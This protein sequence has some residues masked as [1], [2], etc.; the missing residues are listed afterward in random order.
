MDAA[1][2]SQQ[3]IAIA[4]LRPLAPAT[5]RNAASTPSKARLANRNRS[6]A[7]LVDALSAHYPAVFRLAGRESFRAVAHRFVRIQQRRSLVPPHLA[8]TFP[9][10]LRSLGR[11]PSIDYVADVAKLEML[12]G[13]TCRAVDAI[14]MR[15]LSLAFL[16]R[17]RPVDLRVV[18][19][20][21][22][23]LFASRFPAVTVW[24]ANRKDSSSF[25]IRQWVA[26][27]ALIVRPFRK[28][29]VRRL[30]AGGLAFLTR[31]QAGETLGAAAAAAKAAAA[32]FDLGAHLALLIELGIVIAFDF[33]RRR[34]DPPNASI[35]RSRPSTESALERP[36]MKR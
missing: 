13:R 4:P 14:P 1:A 12:Y 21:S 36:T 17:E 15:R 16:Q 18:L 11:T 3:A 30:T 25:A 32:E 35:Q 7:A 8:E 27:Q 29:E 28:V 10:F 6:A 34:L 31:L 22:L 20:P 2:A 26:E 19:H 5:L 33:R 23:A 24:E 9:D